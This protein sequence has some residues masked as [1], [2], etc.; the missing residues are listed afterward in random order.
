MFYNPFADANGAIVRE[1]VIKS[2]DSVIIK[3]EPITPSSSKTNDIFHN[4]FNNDQ[5]SA[6]ILESKRQKLIPKSPE[7]EV[8]LIDISPEKARETQQ[9]RMIKYDSEYQAKVGKE[10]FR[11]TF[12]KSASTTSFKDLKVQLRVSGLQFKDPSFIPTIKTLTGGLS[13]VIQNGNKQF[14]LKN[15][16]WMRPSEIYYEYELYPEKILASDIVQGVLPDDYFLSAV[17]SL[18]EFPYRLKSLFEEDKAN[19]EGIFSIRMCVK[20]FWQSVMIDDYIPCEKATKFPAFT[21]TKNNDIWVQL[22]EKAWAKIK[23]G[24]ANIANGSIRELLH[25]FTGSP[26]L[27][28]STANPQSHEKL[29]DEIFIGLGKRYIMI[30]GSGDF[31]EGAELLKSVGIMGAHSYVLYGG[32]QVKQKSGKLLRLVKL[33]NPFANLEW[34]GDWSDNSPL[35]TPDLKSAL[36][37]S[38][39]ND[40]V[41][42]MSF[43]HFLE[44]FTDVQI[45]RIH[46]SYNYNSIKIKSNP[47]K[48]SYFVANVENDGQY[49]FIVDQE[50]QQES[51]MYIDITIVLGK[52]EGDGYTYVSGSHKGE[53][54]IWVEGKLSPGEYIIYVKTPW[55]DGNNNDFTLSIYGSSPVNIEKVPKT[56]ASNFL[57]KIYLHK[58]KSLQHLEDYSY[59][60][61]EKCYRGVE[62][63]DDGFGYVYYKNNSNFILE[64]ELYFKILEGLKLR[65][66]YSGNHS[67][68]IV[69]PNEEKIILLKVQSKPNKIKQVFAEK[70]KFTPIESVEE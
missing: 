20:G 61:V 30:A 48:G 27:N 29:W 13:E 54:E 28:F 12:S 63:G 57:E 35:W 2:R 23:G 22:L 33:R 10:M 65:K 15:I 51:I 39:S 11:K 58:A 17:A 44:Y 56:F 6:L 8:K 7:V 5:S 47:R 18:A 62:I 69:Y 60:D 31:K 46:D 9:R 55:M 49:Y 14:D 64:E 38:N 26:T 19:E 32:Y 16:I 41:F 34:N 36:G 70:V 1:S 3:D 68:V 24:Y 37:Y 43:E 59:W 4:P 52:K 45:C 66:P 42:F 40:G 21:R 50:M 25:T 53:N 67:K